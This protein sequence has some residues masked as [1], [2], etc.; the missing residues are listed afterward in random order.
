MS[1][2]LKRFYCCSKDLCAWKNEWANNDRCFANYIIRSA[3]P[4]IMRRDGKS[5]RQGSKENEEFFKQ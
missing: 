3:C 5:W 2:S 1:E 4:N